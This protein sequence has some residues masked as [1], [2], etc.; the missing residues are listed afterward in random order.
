MPQVDAPEPYWSDDQVTLYLGDCLDILGGLEPDSVDA[1]VTDPPAAVS[2]MGREWDS[3]RG[4]RDKWISWLAGRMEAAAACLKPGGHALVWSLPRTAHWT[5]MAVEDAGLEIRDCIP[6][7]FGSGFPKSLD[8]SKA[9]DKTRRRGYVA[10]ALRLGMDIPGRNLDDWTK[11][12]HS[13]GDRWWGEFKQHLS[14]EQWG[15]IER[16]VVA[17]AHRK[18]DRDATSIQL[19]R[20][21]DDYDITAPATED[22]ARWAGWGTALKPGQEIWWLARKP[23]RGTVAANVLALFFALALPH[24]ETGPNAHGLET[25]TTATSA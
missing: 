7:L 19:G 11:E 4:G 22:A 18:N 2:F 8:V 16:V 23:I 21:A 9:I 15:A 24:R 13:P 14:A 20:K 1:I 6:H 17:H 12:D 5:A 10:A 25:I 3:D